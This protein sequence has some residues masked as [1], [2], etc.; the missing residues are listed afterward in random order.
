MSTNEMESTAKEYR[1]LQAEIKALQ[2]EADALKQQMIREMDKQQVEKMTAGAF[3]INYSVY[4]STRLD[5]SALV[6][7]Q[8]D[9]YS[10]YAKTTA[11][12]RFQVA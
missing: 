1:E 11:V 2:T 3:T 9:I 12:C 6:A 8:P 4:A 10:R 5:T 7:E